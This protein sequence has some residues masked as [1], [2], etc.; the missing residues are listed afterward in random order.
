ML[1]RKVSQDAEHLIYVHG[2]LSSMQSAAPRDATWRGVGTSG[3][4]AKP[5]V[6]S[7]S[8]RA[9]VAGAVEGHEAG[10]GGCAEEDVQSPSVGIVA[11]GGGFRPLGGDLE[12]F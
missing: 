6:A 11:R 7:G 9:E 10:T 8:G 5:A 3:D 12:A 2:R 1:A 4:G